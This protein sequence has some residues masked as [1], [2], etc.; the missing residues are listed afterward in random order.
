MALVYWI[1]LPGHDDMTTQGYVGFTMQPLP[2]RMTAHQKAA[3]QGQ[4]HI[5]CKAIRKH[6]WENLRKSVLCIGTREY[7]LEVEKRLRPREHIG[8]NI[9]IGGGSA[10]IGCS[11][12]A[13]ARNRISEALKGKP[14]SPEHCKFI[15]EMNK[16]RKHS[17]QSRKN[18]REAKKNFF[19]SESHKSNISKAKK[20]I[21]NRAAMK[22][23]AAHAKKNL[24]LT[25]E[26]LYEIHISNPSGYV[27]SKKLPSGVDTLALYRMREHFRAGW[28][29]HLDP[30]YQEWKAAQVGSHRNQ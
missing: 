16:G 12:T 30:E 22:W 13:E 20:G 7:C 24:W 28:N 26:E 2:K 9:G 25:A 21:S 23:K 8:W 4:P 29:P 18:M 17:E 10:F 11:H 27:S 15:A 5:I 3:R 6:G 1:R 14:K 19:F